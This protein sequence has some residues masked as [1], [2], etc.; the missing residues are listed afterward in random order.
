LPWKCNNPYVAWACGPFDPMSVGI[1]C[2]ADSQCAWG[3]V[4]G[5]D[6]SA[7]AGGNTHFAC[8]AP[9]VCTNDSQCGPTQVCREVPNGPTW[10]P[11]SMER[12]CSTLCASDLDCLPMHKCDGT[13]H[14]QPRTCTQCPSYFSC[15]GGTCSVPTCTKDTDCPGGYCV[16]GYC[17]GSLGTC[18]PFCF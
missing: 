11:W 17:A 8:R 2:S 15:T 4:C 12:W 6:A 1:P 5:Q 9:V 10:S 18:I 13:G 14:C 3:L 16:G 7:P